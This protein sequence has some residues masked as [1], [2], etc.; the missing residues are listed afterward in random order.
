M[1]PGL[2]DPP[3]FPRRRQHLSSLEEVVAD[4]LFDVDML[5]R[6]AG[7]DGGQGVPVITA[8]DDDGVDLRII[9]IPAQVHLGLGALAGLFLKFGCRSLHPPPVASL[10]P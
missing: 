9:Q 1:S 3:V 2:D 4:R 10:S 5:S 6:L 8:C 7:P